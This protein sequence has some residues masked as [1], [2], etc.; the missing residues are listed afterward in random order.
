MTQAAVLYIRC[1]SA[2]QVES[3]LG[4]ADQEARCR[5]YARFRLARRQLPN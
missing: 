3:G 4:L 2:E 1:S 5:S